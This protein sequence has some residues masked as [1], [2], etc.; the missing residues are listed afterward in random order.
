M[1]RRFGLL[2]LVGL[3]S[4][5]FLAGAIKVGDRAPEIRFDKLLP[6]QP[7]ANASFRALAG[8]AVVLEFWAT[9]CAPCVEEIPHLNALAEKFKGRP[10]VFLSVTDED[11]GVIE[12]FLKKRPISGLVGIAHAQSP[13][14][15]YG[16]VYPRAVL[17]DA[18]G[19]IAGITHPVMLKE[20]ALEDLLA[21]RPLSVPEL[22]SP[23]KTRKGIWIEVIQEPLLNLVLQPSG[24]SDESSVRAERDR[25]IMK[26]ANARLILS[27]LYDLPPT[28][29][30][31]QP[32]ESPVLYDL[33]FQVPGAS[34][35]AFRW[36]AREAVAAALRLKISRETRQTDVW[37]LSK[38]EAKPAA[39]L[40]P[41]YAGGLTWTTSPGSL[42]LPLCDMAELAQAL[43]S[44][45]GKPVIDETG[46]TGKYDFSL[47]YDPSDPN[48]AIAA[49]RMLGFKVEA[50]RRPIEFLVVTKAE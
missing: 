10:I 11:P 27:A 1:R 26:G 45:T 5:A 22:L 14:E 19:N 25:L 6:E 17:V 43:E 24:R 2:A 21:G 3:A 41:A 20:A 49:M 37:I 39:L 34:Q 40:D 47:A 28:R 38:P 18:R 4:S 12:A 50:G 44:A 32:L 48:G 16:E 31:G 9:W 29:M 35:T 23:S 15:D 13:R 36:V 7:T 8:K 42:H 33:S 46:I 30:T